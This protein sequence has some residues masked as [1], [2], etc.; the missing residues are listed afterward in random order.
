M[1]VALCRSL[2]GGSH[3]FVQQSCVNKIEAAVVVVACSGASRYDAPAL[4]VCTAL[5]ACLI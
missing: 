3:Q 2:H 4:K 1:I 5:A